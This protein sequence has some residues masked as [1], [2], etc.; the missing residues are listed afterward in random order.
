[1]TM[2][3]LFSFALC[4]CLAAATAL[5][6]QPV[7][8]SAD[9]RLSGV[10]QRQKLS[11][12][13]LLSSLDFRNIGPT[14][15]SGRVTDVDVNP[16]NPTEFYV[17][18]ASGGLWHT[19]NNGTTFTPVFDH[20]AVMT[21]GDIAVDWNNKV[22]WVGTGEVN[23]SRSSYSGV[24][25]FRS[26]DGGKTWEHR[27]LPE[28]HHIGRIILNPIDPDM[29]WV[30]VLGHLYSPNAE[31][32]VYM[33]TDGGITWQRTLFV[34]E[35]TGAVDLVID[36]KTQTVM[37]ATTWQRER[38]AWNFSEGGEGSAVWRS[39]DAGRTWTRLTVAGSGFP[40]GKGT[41]RIGVAVSEMGTLWAVVDNQNAKP[42][43]KTATDK[44]ELTRVQ[45]REM[46][47]EAFLKLDK[48]KLEKYLSDNEFP[49][50]YGVDAVIDMVR[51]DK[52]APVALVE[53]LEDANKDLFDTEI[54][55]AEVYRS[56]DEGKT[57]QKTNTGYLD[58]LFNTYGYY[59]AQIHL[60]PQKPETVYLLG[61]EIVKSDD[62]GHTFKSING[63]NVH[64]DHHAL[65][66]DPRK[67]GHLVNGNDGGINI[68]YDDGASWQKCNSPA[69]AQCYA[70]N[71]DDAKP[72]NV[73]AGLQDNGV[74]T[75]PASTTINTEWHQTGHNPFKEIM[76]GD[77][78]QIMIDPRD[79][80]TVYTGFQFGYYYR[81][82]KTTGDGEP[83]QPK[84]NLGER[85]LRFNWQT[86]ILLS[87]HQPDILYFGS[88]KL[89]RSLDKGKTWETLS[90]DLT[91]GGQKG[92][93]PYGTI[94]TIS[95]SPTKFGLLYVGTDDGLLHI[96]RDGGNTWTRITNGLPERLWV[97]RVSASAHDQA[98]VYAALNGYRCD[99]FAAYLYVSRDYGQNWQPIGTDLPAEPINVVKEDPTNPN[100]I[101]VG[102]DH[103][104]YASLDGG[105]TFMTLGNLPNVPVHDLAV[106]PR[107]HQLVVGTH[108]RSIFVGDIKHLQQ[109]RDTLLAKPIYAF[110]VPNTR[111]N[112]SW[113]RKYNGY[114]T[115]DTPTVSLPI[116]VQDSGKA[117][118]TVST[119]K[120]VVIRQYTANTKRG[121]NN[122]HYDLSIEPSR[123][124][125]YEKAIS[126]ADQPAKLEKAD[127][128]LCYIKRGKYNIT[129]EQNGHKTTL[130]W[131]VE[132]K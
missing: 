107:A 16:N 60:S 75:G 33:T 12:K 118:I 84:H 23:S 3:Y 72:Y 19:T 51:S 7:A 85:P 132:D 114:A 5:L 31:R 79:N 119:E 111:P 105:T 57:W 18:Y 54:I 66:I 68:S 87:K 86:P 82:N 38:R 50:K 1:M 65:W 45:L 14:V 30:A 36:P 102:T 129:I 56:D 17:A 6:A 117:T 40:V 67:A 91:L 49:E 99:D 48:K 101:Y 96:S 55:G 126:T 106:Q 8:M 128:G 95:E 9:M 13:S 115:L 123:I 97:S 83:I 120:G 2:K 113:G 41:G 32:G 110:E 108:G 98:T 35:N 122:L 42:D 130:P 59:F 93:V 22:I 28:S 62:G 26:A 124:A 20:E 4:I 27:G 121:L 15:Q 44:G 53:Y 94:T 58:G 88:N 76:G 29:V 63:D 78:M 127:N 112:S 125:A 24:G 81:I 80:N 39:S 10:A 90:A 47:K 74:W 64:A 37:Y 92:D 46:T 109:L 73:Y 70:I 21:I 103:G 69:V 116:F 71:V 100:I 52:I 11:E 77:G 34:D 131:A 89:H 43:T 104:L 25:L 61:Y